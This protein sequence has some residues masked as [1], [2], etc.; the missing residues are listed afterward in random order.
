M[1]RYL[2][3]MLGACLIAMLPTEPVSAQGQC[4]FCDTNPPPQGEGGG[5]PGN[6][7]GGNG[8]GNG[9]AGGNG[10]GNNGNGNNGNGNGNG[11]GGVG[12]GNGNG[13]A[14]DLFIES[15]I[16]FGRLIM[17]GAGEG[18]VLLDPTT[19]MKIVAGQLEDFGGFTVQGRAT[20]VGRRFR[21][22]QIN[23]PNRV[24][25]RDPRG[26]M[27][28]LRDFETNLSALPTLDADGVLEFTFTGTLVTDSQIGRGGDLRGTIP[29]TVD[30]N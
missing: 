3:L 27:A 10:N 7:P 24:I 16:D 8:N 6:G 17:I 5:R 19:G 25:M 2:A 28:E 1:F 26:G 21:Q 22:V 29:I 23:F 30:Y 9:N 13:N 15:D 11:N 14:P 12:N 20:I 4:R 18:S